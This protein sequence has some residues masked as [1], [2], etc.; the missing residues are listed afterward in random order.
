MLD[1]QINRPLPQAVLTRSLFSRCLQTLR[2]LSRPQRRGR[3]D[4]NRSLYRLLFER[5]GDH[6]INGFD[7]ID[8]HDVANFLWY[9]GELLTVVF[10]QENRVDAKARSRKKLYFY[11]TDGQ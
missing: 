6:F 2:R 11:A 8:I 1:G 3:F 10:G 9:F 4:G 7:Q 5:E